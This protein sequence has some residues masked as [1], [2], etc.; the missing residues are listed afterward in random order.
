MPEIREQA[1][2]TALQSVTRNILILKE[3]QSYHQVKTD[4]GFQESQKA[5]L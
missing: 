4:K 5:V 1:A 2:L 3:K